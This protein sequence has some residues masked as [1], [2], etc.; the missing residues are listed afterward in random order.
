MGRPEE[1]TSLIDTQ[2]AIPFS[3]GVLVGEQFEDDTECYFALRAQ[4]VE[5]RYYARFTGTKCGRRALP[6][7]DCRRKER[8]LRR[9]RPLGR[10]PAPRGRL[11]Q[12]PCAFEPRFL[13]KP[14]RLLRL[15]ASDSGFP[16]ALIPDREWNGQSHHDVGLAWVRRVRP[17]RPRPRSPAWGSVHDQRSGADSLRQWIPPRQLGQ[18]AT[19]RG[20]PA[21]AIRH[22]GLRRAIQRA[23]THWT[24]PTMLSPA[25]DC[26]AQPV[27]ASL[28]RETSCPT[29]AASSAT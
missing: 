2:Q 24:G 28:A 10:L 22:G 17:I 6:E 27:R 23:S 29:R 1:R 4:R 26:S 12:P 21:P 8:V 7:A 5:H 13:G 14:R 15:C 16:S 18:T 25:P 11:R 9:A 20:P 3:D 19:R